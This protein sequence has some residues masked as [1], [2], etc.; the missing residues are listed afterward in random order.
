[1]QYV[2]SPRFASEAAIA[3]FMR[4][5]RLRARN[6]PRHDVDRAHAIVRGVCRGAPPRPVHCARG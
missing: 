6:S 2:T 5:V 4:Q 3:R 1:M